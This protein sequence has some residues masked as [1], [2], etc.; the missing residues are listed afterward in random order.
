MKACIALIVSPFALA[1]E[2][3]DFCNLRLDPTSCAHGSYCKNNFDCHGLFWTD[4]THAQLCVLGVT[5]NCRTDFLVSCE[6]ARSAIGDSSSIIRPV[7]TSSSPAVSL[8]VLNTEASRVLDD[9]GCT[10]RR[11]GMFTWS[12]SY[13]RRSNGELLDFLASSAGQEYACGDLYINVADYSS[14]GRIPDPQKLVDFIKAYR[15]VRGFDSI[16]YLTYGDVTARDGAAMMT[17][18]NTFFDWVASISSSDAALMGMI[19][20]SYDVERLDAEV[21]RAALLLGRERR[22]DTA[23]GESNLKIQ[24]TLDGDVNILSTE[25]VMQYADSALAMLYSNTAANLV[26]S[27]RWLVTTQCPRCLDDVYSHANYMAKITIMVEASC[28]MG[29]GCSEKSMCIFDGPTEGALYIARTFDE[30][31]AIL[32]SGE[33]LSRDHF[34]RLFDPRSL[35]AIHNFEWFRCYAPFDSSLYTSCTGYHIEAASCRAL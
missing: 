11:W 5:A 12:T 14:P 29:R 2:C 8:T 1:D 15:R 31:E 22:R 28:R 18:T 27:V 33:V 3:S 7:A 13:Y 26:E 20:V 30:T 6:E 17:F 9:G 32:S 34:S 16:V 21:S 4:E 25:Y 19:G 24:H 35:W 10:G 23:F